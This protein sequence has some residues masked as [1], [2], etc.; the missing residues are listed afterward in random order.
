VQG[1]VSIGIERAPKECAVGNKQL[2][3]TTSQFYEKTEEVRER[4]LNEAKRLGIGLQDMQRVFRN[5]KSIPRTAFKRRLVEMGF[6]LADFPDDDFVVLDE[7]NDGSISA[8]E[9]IQFFKQGVK[10]ND[11]TNEPPPPPPAPDDLV[12][13]PI[14]LAGVLT[15]IVNGAKGLRRGA[16]WFAP[17]STAEAEAQ[18]DSSKICGP[19]G[20]PKFHYDAEAAALSHKEPVVTASVASTATIL[21]PPLPPPSGMDAGPG[22][23]LTLRPMTPYNEMPG[24]EFMSVPNTLTQTHGM[25]SPR[26]QYDGDEEGE[27]ISHFALDA[28]TRLH[29]DPIL[30]TTEAKRSSTFLQM[31]RNKAK[32][33]NDGEVGNKGESGLLIS[34][35]GLKHFRCEKQGDLDMLKY[36][37]MTNEN[38]L[39]HVAK[40]AM[41]KEGGVKRVDALMAYPSPRSKLNSP[42]SADRVVGGRYAGYPEDIWDV[43]VDRVA[44]ICSCRSNEAVIVARRLNSSSMTASFFDN[45]QPAPSPIPT[46][47]PTGKMTAKGGM[48]RN[49]SRTTLHRG[50]ATAKSGSKSRLVSTQALNECLRE[51]HSEISYVEIFRRIIP[52]PL[53]SFSKVR[54]YF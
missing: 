28:G 53:C 25:L 48:S 37:G 49:P 31:M 36:L 47:T 18:S 20:R 4:I 22:G 2:H 6:S 32:E 7:N 44:V 41:R 3:L 16:A 10:M 9:F 19:K 54:I 33:E 45:I 27:P 35:H 39:K 11:P 52:I 38:A 34:K 40:H 42:R 21:P 29:Q 23:K 46:P 51:E 1:G 12:Y 8:E 15:V 5:D 43:F 30:Q 14:D 13:Q 24:G 26:S 17:V 50:T